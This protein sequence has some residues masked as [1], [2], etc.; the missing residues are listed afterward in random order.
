MDKKTVFIYHTSSPDRYGLLKELAKE[1]RKKMTYAET[2]LWEKL[3]LFPKPIHFRRQHIIGDFIVDFVYLE[4]HLVIEVDGEYHNT[5]KQSLND[6][7]RTESL[8]RQGFQV[9]RFTNEQVVTHIEDVTQQIYKSIN[10]K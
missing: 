9:I 1:K 10:N 8:N 5:P 3:K 4:K 2:L 6:Q 7:L